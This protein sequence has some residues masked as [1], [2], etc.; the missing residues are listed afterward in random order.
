MAST[1]R[2][3]KTFAIDQDFWELNPQIATMYPYSQLYERDKK[4]GSRL[5]WC[6]FF[7]QDPDKYL[8]SYAQ[9]GKKTAKKKLLDSKYLKK[10]ELE[11][12]VFKECLEAYPTDFMTAAEHTLRVEIDS[13]RS[14]ARIIENLR[15]LAEE[16]MQK[17][18]IVLL[19][20]LQRDADKVYTNYE[21]ASTKF[22]QEKKDA[23][24]KKG[25][26]SLSRRERSE[27]TRR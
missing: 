13:L 9:F 14:R 27:L 12:D 24:M 4:Q 23:K 17:E 11:D 1:I 18:H 26:Q 6:I 8:N 7:I 15:K 3:N 2:I 25:K 16:T 10:E 21:K 20:T 22:I 5:M 19:N